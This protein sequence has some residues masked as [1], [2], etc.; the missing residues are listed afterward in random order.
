LGIT[1]RGYHPDNNRNIV[2]IEQFRNI[3]GPPVIGS[4]VLSGKAEIG[5]EVFSNIIPIEVFDRVTDFDESILDT[6]C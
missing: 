5:M 3:G 6:A 4:T 1:E 2:A